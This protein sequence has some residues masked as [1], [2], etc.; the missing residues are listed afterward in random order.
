LNGNGHGP[1]YEIEGS[2]VN[3][4]IVYLPPCGESRFSIRLFLKGT[5]MDQASGEPGRSRELLMGAFPRKGP[6][7]APRQVHGTDVIAA[8]AGAALPARPSGDG[9]LLDRCGIEASLRFADCFPVVI[10]SLS[11]SPRIILLHSGFKGTVLNIA[12]RAA[13]SLLG[14]MGADP[15][16]TWAW[17]GPGIGKNHYFR[18]KDEPWT[19]RGIESFSRH[20][21]SGD[22]DGVFFDLGGEIRKQLGDAGIEDEKICSVPLCTYRDNDV[23]YSYR[24]GDRENRLFLLAWI[25]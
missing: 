8:S 7:V 21:M 18:K 2:A 23:C 9:V 12:G 17:I 4:S 16:R 5:A 10:A 3:D 11:P 6:L 19:R 20:N 1:A 25:E 13:R 15:S 24:R 14:K 22:G